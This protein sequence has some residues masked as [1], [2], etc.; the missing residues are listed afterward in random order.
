LNQGKEKP[1]SIN[2]RLISSDICVLTQKH[3]RSVAVHM[4]C[5]WKKKCCR[6]QKEESES[7]EHV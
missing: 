5:S 6:E 3:R 4:T 7:A 1:M 2:V